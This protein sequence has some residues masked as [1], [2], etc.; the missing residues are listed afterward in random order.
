M[1]DST[2]DSVYCYPHSEILKNNYGEKDPARLEKIERMLTG[3]RLIDLYRRPLRGRFD[4][5]H[6][7]AVHH[8]LFQDLFSWAG[9][10]RTVEIAKGYFFCRCEYIEREIKRLL[11]QLKAEGYLRQLARDRLPERLGYYLAE[12]NAVH[13]FRDGN[14]RTQREF[15]RELSL[16][17]GARVDYSRVPPETMRDASIAAFNGDY[18][19]MTALFRRCTGL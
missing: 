1:S 18:A 9:K 11:R 12:I 5:R 16:T 7:Q 8:Y 10:L 4:L 19:P 3:A 17:C 2:A 15:I 13:P 6:L 14:G